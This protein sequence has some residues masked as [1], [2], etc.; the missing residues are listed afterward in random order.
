MVTRAS[1]SNSFFGGLI[2]I[3]ASAAAASTAV[4]LL[5]D[6]F[7]TTLIPPFEDSRQTVAFATFGTAIALLALSLVIQRKLSAI[8]ARTIAI[9]CGLL[10]AAAAVLF[11]HFRDNTR[12][13][14]YRYPPAS[15]SHEG[16]K[17]HIR[18]KLHELG[19][20]YVENKTVAQAVFEL[21]GPDYVSSKGLL[22]R[23]ADRLSAISYMERLYVALAMLLTT[24]L[25]TAGLAVWRQ[26][27]RK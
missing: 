27:E 5:F 15:I 7:L 23:E 24:G 1:Q 20:K 14:V 22:W 12:T 13:Y 19:E 6:S 8:R 18:G 10:L 25:F 2:A 21:G 4:F 17:L 3:I 26:Q 16:Q 9:S 11:L